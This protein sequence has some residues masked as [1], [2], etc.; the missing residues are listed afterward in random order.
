MIEREKGKRVAPADRGVDSRRLLAFLDDV[1]AAGLELHNLVLW[2]DGAVVA[3][4]FHWPYA[5]HRPR[6]THSITKS[7]TA[8]AVGLLIDSGKLA[9]ADRVI[10]FFP[11]ILLPADSLYRRMIVEDLLTMRAGHAEEVSGSVW[12]GIESSWVEEFFRI[13]ILHPPGTH[14]VYS[15]AA[16][17]MLSAIV[18][19]VTGETL[20]DY[21]APRLFAP[22]GIAEWRWDSGPDG[23]NPGGNGLTMT[24]LD[25]MKLGILHAQH[26]LWDGQRILPEWWVEAATRA[27]GAPAYGYHWVV[28][29]DY[30]AALGQFVQ[31]C[32]V[33][34]EA[35]AVLMI[36]G[37]I[38]GSSLIRPHLDRHF[39]A[40]F[41]GGAGE[42]EDAALAERLGGWAS[43]DLLVSA[44]APG[45]REGMAGRWTAEPNALGIEALST[46][47]SDDGIVLTLSDMAGDHAVA[48][49]E[50]D[51]LEGPSFLPG[52]SLHHGYALRGTPTVAG[53]RWLGPDRL[54]LILH[55]V[56]TCFRDTILLTREGDSL[57]LDRKVNINSGARAWP[58]L[59]FRRG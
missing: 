8:C 19:R 37:A 35:G 27:Q 20:S 54:E 10:D 30:Y 36:N 51:W 50:G 46:A 34:P 32:A 40:A 24:S 28:A 17:Y 42:A 21:L 59:L 2:R 47:F 26:G 14:Y 45:G 43:P 58:S 33:Y 56:E 52:A 23:I 11:E 53:Y 22:L 16:S 57:R 39:P 18:S 6:M 1:E 15:S 9:L 31:M 3:E 4:G 7:F 38:D 49:S 12:R 41:D 29:P 13:P 44:A 5:P 48:A 25:C 55:F